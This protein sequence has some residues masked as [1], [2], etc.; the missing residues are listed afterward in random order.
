MMRRM[1]M[2]NATMRR[3]TGFTLIELLAVVAIIA[4]LATLAV[5]KFG[6]SKRR[7]YLAAMKSDLHGVATIAE[8]RYTLDNSYEY[9]TTPTGSA[10]ITLTFVGT[11]NTWTATAHHAKLPGVTC[12]MTYA[13]NLPSAIDCQ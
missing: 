4:L 11:I 13:P 12:T 6:D 10:G 1:H 2:L 9:M 3:R 8:T 5:A 7:A